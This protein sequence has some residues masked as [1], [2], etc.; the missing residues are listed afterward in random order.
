MG[1]AGDDAS[2]RPNQ[3]LTMSLRLP[4]LAQDRWRPVVDTVGE[5]IDY[6]GRLAKYGAEPP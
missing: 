6:A 3:I 4:I 1:K 2:V 5:T